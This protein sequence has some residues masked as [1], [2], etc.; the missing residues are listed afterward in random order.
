MYT[1]RCVHVRNFSVCEGSEL[2]QSFPLGSRIVITEFKH[3]IG[4]FIQDFLCLF[5]IGVQLIYNVIFVS[6]VQ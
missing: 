1:H 3:L 5:F 6:G 4:S 2:F